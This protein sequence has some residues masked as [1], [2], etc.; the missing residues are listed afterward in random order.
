MFDLMLRCSKIPSLYRKTV[1]H[2][3]DATGYLTHRKRR[4]GKLNVT[5]EREVDL[6]GV[7]YV[8]KFDGFTEKAFNRWH[9]FIRT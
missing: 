5:T 9:L 1:W 4:M 3:D 7:R 2:F 8:T 6:D